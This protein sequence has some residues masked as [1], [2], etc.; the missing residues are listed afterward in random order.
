MTARE[1]IIMTLMIGLLLWLGLY[2]QREL[3]TAR[4]ALE[5][6]QKIT[7]QVPK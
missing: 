1:G 7:I 2:P 6:L 3:S 5:D 4:R